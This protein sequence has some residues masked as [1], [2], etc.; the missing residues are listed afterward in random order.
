MYDT[1]QLQRITTRAARRAAQ[2]IRSA[3]R[4]RNPTGWQMKGASDFATDIDRD[5]EAMIAETVLAAF[6]D[7]TVL[8]EE[9]SPGPLG[10]GLTWIVDPLDGTT[11]FLHGYPAYAVSVAVAV[12]GCPVAASVIDVPYDRTYEAVAGGGARCDGAALRASATDDP[13][14]ALVG[15]GFPF[16]HPELLPQYLKD[17]S[18][19]LT[20]TSGIRRAGSAALDLVQVA[21]GTLDGFWELSLAPWDVAAGALI[22]REA[23]AVVTDG[24]GHTDI[25]KTGSIVAGN[26]VIHQW[27][28]TVLGK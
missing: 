13:T 20:S 24:A 16:K 4:P 5:A 11:N 19:I 10:G 15:T 28:C 21:S 1:A 7:S 25:L 22:A 9:L 3:D 6:P 17:F 14:F 2:H 26:P 18:T 8:G 12:D 27:L 23:G